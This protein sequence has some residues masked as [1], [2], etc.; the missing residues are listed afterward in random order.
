MHGVIFSDKMYKWSLNFFHV[1]ASVF[2]TTYLNLLLHINVGNIWYIFDLGASAKVEAHYL[3][4]QIIRH[5]KQ[6]LQNTLKI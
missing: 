1:K 2:A 5:Y 4:L 6:N 3:K